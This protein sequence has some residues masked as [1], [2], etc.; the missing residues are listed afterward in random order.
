M[1]S[2]GPTWAEKPGAVLVEVWE[3][4][5]NGEI[6]QPHQVRRRVRILLSGVLSVLLLLWSI[7]RRPIVQIVH[8]EESVQERTA[9]ILSETPLIGSTASAPSYLSLCQANIQQM[10]TTIWQS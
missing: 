9:R 8:R 3:P 10:A 1:K 7:S 6:N 2:F 5:T 4:L